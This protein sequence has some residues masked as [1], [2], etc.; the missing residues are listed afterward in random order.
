MRTSLLTEEGSGVVK[1][2]PRKAIS[3]GKGQMAKFK[4]FAIC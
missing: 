2:G 4:W 3:N 1:T